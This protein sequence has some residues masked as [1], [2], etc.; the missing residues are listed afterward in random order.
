MPYYYSDYERENDPHSL[1]DIE[2]F[3]DYW[4]D[5]PS[6][7][8]AIIWESREIGFSCPF[9]GYPNNDPNDSSS[10]KPLENGRYGYGFAFGMPGYLWD[11]EPTGPFETEEEAL[12]EA[13]EIAGCE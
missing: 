1:P 2:V 12:A 13:K 11:S 10:V 9:C 8:A 5:C 7:E 3:F 6:C 4:G